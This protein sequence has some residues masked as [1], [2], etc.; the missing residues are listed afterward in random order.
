MVQPF[1]PVLLRVVVVW[2]TA[3]TLLSGCGR[4]GPLELPPSS[5][6]AATENVPSV[7]SGSLIGLSVYALA[8]L[9]GAGLLF[10]NSTWQLLAGAAGAAGA[11]AAALAR[12]ATINWF[13]TRNMSSTVVAVTRYLPL[14][15]KEAPCIA[16]IATR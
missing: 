14:T 13:N 8:A 5:Q 6:A 10:G 11:A 15:M 12:S 7:Q 4:K 1:A 3:A 16:W 9:L 2:A